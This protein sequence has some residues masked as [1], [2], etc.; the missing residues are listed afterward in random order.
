ML[1]VTSFTHYVLSSGTRT[2]FTFGGGFDLAGR[3]RI[4]GTGRALIVGFAFIL[5]GE[6]VKSGEYGEKFRIICSL[7]QLL[8]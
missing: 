8:L 2:Y 3:L 5:C 7:L 6:N 1:N 4:K